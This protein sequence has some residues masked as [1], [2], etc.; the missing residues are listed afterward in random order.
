MLH[1]IDP[2]ADGYA[3]CAGQLI[4]QEFGV[5]ATWSLLKKPTYQTIAANRAAESTAG[6]AIFERFRVI[7]A[8]RQLP[9]PQSAV[10]GPAIAVVAYQVA[11]RPRN[12]QG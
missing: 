3:L 7:R 5:S 12:K 11:S 4:P 2:C 8:P 1:V 9:W 10:H 6:T